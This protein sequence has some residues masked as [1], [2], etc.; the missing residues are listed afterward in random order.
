[1]KS[2]LKTQI[3]AIFEEHREKPED[4]Y[5]PGHFLDFLMPDPPARRAVMN[6]FAGL[7]RYNAFV[8]AVQEERGVYF[9]QKD[10]D[11]HYSLDAFCE[12]VKALQ[13]SPKSS[14]QSLNNALKRRPNWNFMILVNVIALSIIVALRQHPFVAAVLGLILTFF[15]YRLYRFHRHERDYLV[16]LNEQIKAAASGT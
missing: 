3:I 13:N 10:R 15:N 7:R 2:D 9:S 14:L 11:A 8:D 6:S 1:M 5:N 16:R 4:D 12:R